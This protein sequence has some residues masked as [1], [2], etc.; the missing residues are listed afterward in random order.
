VG[1]PFHRERD[2]R[3]SEGPRVRILSFHRRVIREPDL[4]DQGLHRSALDS[5]FGRFGIDIAFDYKIVPPLTKP[6]ALESETLRKFAP[7]TGAMGT[8]FLIKDPEVIVGRSMAFSP[9]SE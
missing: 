3:L 1:A 4:L 8:N 9:L 5:S 6:E 2:P 7:F